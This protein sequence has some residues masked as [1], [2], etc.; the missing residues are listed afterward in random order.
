VSA[1]VAPVAGTD[2]G[3]DL[4]DTGSNATLPLAVLALVLVG[5]G[6]GVVVVGRRAGADGLG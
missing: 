4:P 2:S 5:V 6:A 1:D 3:G